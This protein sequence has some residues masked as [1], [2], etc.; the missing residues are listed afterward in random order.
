MILA[1]KYL[2]VIFSYKFPQVTKC[3]RSVNNMLVLQTHTLSLP[4]AHKWWYVTQ[5]SFF[6]NFLKKAGIRDL[7][8]RNFTGLLVAFICEIQHCLFQCSKNL[9]CVTSE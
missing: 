9:F 7:K 8:L 2:T 3:L 4:S 6:K 5:E 1:C